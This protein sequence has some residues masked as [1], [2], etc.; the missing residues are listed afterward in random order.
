MPQPLPPISVRKAGGILTYWNIVAAL[1]VLG[2]VVFLA[3]AT[4]AAE[5]CKFVI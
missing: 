2:L 1:L 5:T 3:E 4:R